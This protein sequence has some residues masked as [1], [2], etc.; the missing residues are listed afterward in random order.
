MRAEDSRAASLP[1][2]RYADGI[3]SPP[4]PRIPTASI[5]L[6]DDTPPP[7]A[8]HT[9]L[10]PSAAP[11]AKRDY[12]SR[13]APP[14]ERNASELL[15]SG[16][17]MV[18]L[19]QSFY[20]DG[21]GEETAGEPEEAGL[22]LRMPEGTLA[23]DLEDG[24]DDMSDDAIW[25]D[26]PRWKRTLVQFNITHFGLAMGTAAHAALWRS[27]ALDFEWV[28]IPNGIWYGLWFVA[29]VLFSVE[30]LVYAARAIV[31]PGGLLRDVRNN[32]FV[33]FFAA[34]V[35]VV[36]SIL[37]AV[38]DIFEPTGRTQMGIAYF[39]MVYQVIFALY[40]YGDWL[41]SRQFMLNQVDP[42]YQMA[43]IGFLLVSRVNSEHGQV[44]AAEFNLA[45]GLLFWIVVF[46]AL[47]QNVASALRSSK[48]DP[49]PT[50]FLFIA[51]PAAAALAIVAL[52][53]A[54]GAD[55][56]LVDG[57][58]FFVMVD[59][60]LFLLLLRLLPIW[61]FQKFNVAW[62]AYIFPLSTAASTMV[63]YANWTGLLIW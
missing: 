19:L 10:P 29:V 50:M 21:R 18:N 55:K 27:L 61:V 56:P 26:T 14:G 3:P 42:T 28:N 54:R 59:L 46:V 36:T 24:A 31:F 13:S 52:E 44:N 37:S 57:A 33:N 16:Q 39:L 38:P 35:I 17:S 8:R 1:P 15:P 34:P 53:R 22:N 23:V 11:G 40:I 43:V 20:G 30:V 7:P 45:V 4:L 47:F 60:F 62:W 48:T 5:P 32:R 9:F 25:E 58:V 41:F 12:S 63:L 6:D 51:P 2:G 49:S